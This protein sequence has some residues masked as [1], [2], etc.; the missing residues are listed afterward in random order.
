MEH[1]HHLDGPAADAANAAEALDDCHVRE[2]RE[3]GRRWH[4]T[5]DGLAR[6][7]LERGDLGGRETGA[8]QSRVR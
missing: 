6:Q 1:Q 8:T 4:D 3:F 5:V 7:I 2:Q